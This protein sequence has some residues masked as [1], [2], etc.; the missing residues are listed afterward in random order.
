MSDAKR[1]LPYPRLD[2]ALAPAD[3]QSK[4]RSRP[5]RH[6]SITNEIS[7]YKQYKAWE[8]R[9]RKESKEIE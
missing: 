9:M 2:A 8:A 5:N 1:P 6:A 3:A 4:P 7:T